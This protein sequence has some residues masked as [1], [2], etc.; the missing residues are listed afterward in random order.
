[1]RLDLQIWLQFLNNQS[2]FCRPLTHFTVISA[3]DI[4]MYTDSSRNQNLGCG[5]VC[6]NDWFMTKWEDGFIQN[7][8]P[9]I[10][11]LELYAVTVAIINWIHRFEGKVVSLF[12]DN[13]SVVHMINSQTSNCKNCM[14]LIRFIALKGMLH[15]VIIKAKHVT[16]KNNIVSDCLSRLKYQKFRELTGNKYNEH[17]TPIPHEL[18]PVSKI[19]AK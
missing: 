15:N 3:E 16:T 6:N 18:W 5:G 11:Y 12:C 7:C 1:M 4:D 14:V 10:G 8:Q 19:Y 13:M 9:S 2:I 17:P